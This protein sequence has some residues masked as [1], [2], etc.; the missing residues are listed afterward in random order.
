MAVKSVPERDADFW[1]A[2]GKVVGA[3]VLDDP[4]EEPV[5]VEAP[6]FV[7]LD[8]GAGAVAVPP[9]LW[10]TGVDSPG[11][12]GAVEAAEM[13][14]TPLV[15]LPLSSCSAIEKLPLVAKTSLM[16]ATFTNC[17]VNPD[18]GTKR[19]SGIPTEPR[20]VWTLLATPMLGLN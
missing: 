1:A 7:G 3:P 15:E 18:P 10:V 4:D 17:S 8:V 11:L 12:P 9:L 13:V 6:V 5:F 16:F 20:A 2:P 19:G 14:E